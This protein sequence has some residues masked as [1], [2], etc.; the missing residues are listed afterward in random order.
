[1][2]KDVCLY[3]ITII[4]RVFVSSVSFLIGFIGLG[5]RSFFFFFFFFTFFVCKFAVVLPWSLRV[6]AILLF[7]GEIIYSLIER[8]L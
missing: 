1:M 7:S 8:R 2:Q 6:N 5:L 4:Q 3:Y